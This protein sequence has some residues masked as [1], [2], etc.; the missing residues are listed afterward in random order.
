MGQVT[1]IS[2][3]L[4][5]PEDRAGEGSYPPN[6]G[7]RRPSST[8]FTAACVRSET[9]SLERMRSRCL[10]TVERE[11]CSCWAI[12]RLVLPEAM[13]PRTS[14]S[15]G[16]SGLAIQA[17]EAAGSTEGVGCVCGRTFSCTAT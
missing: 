12:W 15:L 6:P 9:P 8:A 1:H 10:L 13:W 17:A 4:G 2:E 16:V 7:G 3:D 14:V 11:R 5:T